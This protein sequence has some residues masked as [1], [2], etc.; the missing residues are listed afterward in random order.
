[1]R[2][3]IIALIAL[4]LSSYSISGSAATASTSFIKINEVDCNNEW[5]EIINTGSLAINVKNFE[6]RLVDTDGT[7]LKDSFTLPASKIQ[8]G[9]LKTY[10]EAQLGFAIGCGDK[11]FI[12]KDATS[13][14]LDRVAI[15]NLLDNVSWSRFSSGWAGG[16]PT[17]NVTNRK[18]PPNSPIDQA[19]WI[20]DEMQSFRINLSI[21]QNNLD[22]LVQNPKE[23]VPATFRFRD[24]QDNLLPTSGALAVGVRTKGSVGSTGGGQVNIENGKIGLKIKFNWSVPGQE[25]LGLKRLTLN[26]MMQDQSMVRDVLSYRLF[27]DMGLVAPRTGFARVYINSGS[28]FEYKG[29]YLNLESY[30]E[31]MMARWRTSMQ[32]MFDA[33][34]APSWNRFSKACTGTWFAPDIRVDDY[35][36]NFEVDR[37]DPENVEDLGALADALDKQESLSSEA[38]KIVNVSQIGK[39]FA[40]EKYI[41]HW[42]GQ[43]GSPEWTPNNYRIFTDKNNKV[44]L[45]PWGTDGTWYQFENVN[46]WAPSGQVDGY[47]P[48]YSAQSKLFM[49]CIAD[50]QCNSEYLKALQTIAEIAQYQDLAN[51]LFDAHTEARAADT[52]RWSD[53]LSSAWELSKTL[54][55]IGNRD[56]MA[57]DYVKDVATGEIRWQPVNKTIKVGG[58]LTSAHLN[59][60]SDV[61]GSFKY[62]QKIGKALKKGT[63]SIKVTFTPENLDDWS[64]QQKIVKFTVK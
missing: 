31:I 3:F 5:V 19:A 33:M 15:P 49:Q 52:V 35:R 64:V 50:D 38:K 32:H 30:D 61:L 12:L 40:V 8:P 60:Y 58:K 6:L 11:S 42:D 41:S 45:L 7:I 63:Y 36:C 1:M 57:M 9:K 44:E 25:F 62:S 59:A 34:W 17:Q 29:L 20:F 56:D 53:E 37:G 48:F 51:E 26:N 16:Q 13:K 28:G 47:E 23:Y 43:S 2:K 46:Q 18:L 54:E 39:F 10:T 14:E 24:A 21:D 55:F 4:V 27:T 22:A